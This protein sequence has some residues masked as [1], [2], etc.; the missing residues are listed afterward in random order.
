MPDESRVGVRGRG[1]S[2]ARAALVVGNFKAVPRRVPAGGSYIEGVF[3]VLGARK[4]ANVCFWHTRLMLEANGDWTY[5][6]HV[7]TYDAAAAT[8]SST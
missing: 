8:G 5:L 1:V 7:D 3:S 6:K 4:I 2:E